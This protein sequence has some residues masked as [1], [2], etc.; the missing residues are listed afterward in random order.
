VQLW[1]SSVPLLKLTDS[2]SKTALL[3]F[4]DDRLESAPASSPRVREESVELSGAGVEP[5]RRRVGR[6]DCAFTLATQK[7]SGGVWRIM[8]SRPLATPFRL[9]TRY[10]A[11]LAGLPFPEETPAPR[12]A[13][14]PSKGAVKK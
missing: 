3:N 8:V 4:V 10:G 9:D 12:P 5:A 1:F 2:F 7:D 11:G 13:Q 14:E 6:T